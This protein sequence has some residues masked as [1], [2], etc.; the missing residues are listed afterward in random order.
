MTDEDGIRISPAED[1]KIAGTG[2]P[3][4]H[5]HQAQKSKRPLVASRERSAVAATQPPPVERKR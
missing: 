2:T 5:D 4:T 3:V 1:A